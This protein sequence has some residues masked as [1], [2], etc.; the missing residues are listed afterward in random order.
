MLPQIKRGR[1][2]DDI[3]QVL[4]SNILQQEFE[5]GQRLQVDE[6]AEQ[7]D[8]SRTPVREALN[9]LAA[10]ELVEIVP[11]SGTYV[12]HPS[13]EDIEE[14]FDLRMALEGLA[15]ERLAESSPDQE[16]L[17]ELRDLLD[18]TE[19]GDDDETI[20]HAEAN[21]SFHERLVEMSGNSKLIQIYRML[22]AHTMMILIHYSAPEWHERWDLEREEHE[23]ILKALE[24]GNPKEA[25][26]AMERH[27]QRSRESLIKDV[28]EARDSEEST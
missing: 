10:E 20:Q 2:A 25:K 27:I 7:L 5:A 6:L 23:A 3:Y 1:I 19:Q 13:V 18:W 14:I 4:R 21:R 12:A 11:R 28:K 9:L 24:Q 15:A 16:K 26:E 8:V 22:N 17:R